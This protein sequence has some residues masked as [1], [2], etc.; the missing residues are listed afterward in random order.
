MLNV[1]TEKDMIPM[2]IKVF[3]FPDCVAPY[4]IDIEF[5]ADGDLVGTM[6]LNT[7]SSCGMWIKNSY[8]KY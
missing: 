6:A 8:K 2:V 4:N 3:W 1:K 7:E 5:D